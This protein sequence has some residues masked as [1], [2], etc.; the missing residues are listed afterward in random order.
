MNM[1][2][3]ML[4]GMAATSFAD[5]PPPP[6]NQYLGI[7][8]GVFNN[9]QENDCR[10]CHNA[11]PP[12]GIPVDNTYL[13]DR[14]HALVG[15]IMPDPTAA[16]FGTPGDA[17]ECLDCH[18]IEWNAATSSFE[19]VVNFRDCLNCHAQGVGAPTVHHVTQL[20][21]VGDCR[22]CHGSFVDSLAY[23]EA[24]GS[25]TP[26]P[27]QPDSSADGKYVPEYP[28]SLVTPWP[29]G[30]PN[31]DDTNTNFLGTEPG[32]CNYCHDGVPILD[33]NNILVGYEQDIYPNVSTHHSTGLGFD[34]N[35]C[36]WC[37][38]LTAD[39]GLAI[40]QCE[41]CHTV[42]TLHNIE[43]DNAGDGIVPNEED[44]GYGHIGNQWDCWGCHGSD[45]I[46]LSAP[47]TGPIIPSIDTISQ[48]KFTA[49]TAATITI[50][51]SS[52]SNSVV[53]PLDGSSIELT[54]VVTVTDSAGV[55]TELTPASLTP[56][57]L[58]VT[59]P[60]NL[61]A[62]NYTL[63]VVK[64]SSESNPKGIVISPQVIIA[65]VKANSDGTITVTGSG[66]SGY[67]DPVAG[68]SV[69]LTRIISLKTGETITEPCAVLSWS[70]TQINVQC[71]AVTG[72]AEVSSV[73]GVAAKNVDLATIK[74]RRR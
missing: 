65:S 4:A 21:Q 67:L 10:G 59:I 43:F 62:G 63:Q 33:A 17:Y 64:A 23:L 25:V 1:T 46:A 19:L 72:T 35:K 57:E 45:G 8:D 31:G 66:F 51:G 73:F 18:L 44:L 30:K 36:S 39:T 12:A 41:E 28:T 24:D 50:N 15:T 49:G 13:P 70:D 20:A 53:N 69:D 40:R 22:A 74:K 6:A 9:L 29:S 37:H 5:A 16:P 71:N 3:L 14:H 2:F 48:Q 47:M 38:D 58:T 32:N 56:T 34:N 26:N 42:A 68:T 61:E 11:N 55:V 60:G 27:G 54:S 7:P 52:F